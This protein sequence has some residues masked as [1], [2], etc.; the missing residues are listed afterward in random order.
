MVLIRT[1]CL[2]VIL[3]CSILRLAAQADVPM[4]PSGFSQYYNVYE[5]VN[6]AIS[7]SENTFKANVGNKQMLGI[8][9][10]V[11]TYYF[12]AFIRVP[13]QVAYKNSPFNAIGVYVFNDREGKYLNRTRFYLN[14]AWHAHLSRKVKFSGGFY[15]GGMSYSVKGSELSGGGSDI[16]P[17]GIIGVQFYGNQ[18]HIGASYNQ[19][20]NNK[21]QPLAEIAILSPYYSFTGHYTQLV[22]EKIRLKANSLVNWYPTPANAKADITLVAEWNARAAVVLGVHENNRLITG[23]E[24]KNILNTEKVL[25][26]SFIYS[27]PLPSAHVRS[28]FLEFG[29]SYQ[30]NPY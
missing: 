28:N 2:F 13:K 1:C 12:N 19:I 22:S 30:L 27:F 5:I 25:N 6:P 10:K 4:S 9:S 14:Y 29:M 3:F 21:V 8:F 17:D 16:V 26:L 24:F 18:F 15:F 20:F 23:I 11:S 7:G